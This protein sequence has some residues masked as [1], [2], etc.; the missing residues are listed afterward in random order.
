MC[1]SNP[2]GSSRSRCFSVLCLLLALAIWSQPALGQSSTPSSPDSESLW[3]ALLP[4]TQ[5][6]PAQYDNFMASLTTQIASLQDSNTQLTQTNSDLRDSN[7]QLIASNQSLTSKNELLTQS[8]KTSQ[9]QAAI[10]E[11]QSAQLQTDLQDSMLSTTRAQAD[12]KALERQTVWLKVY[13]VAL[14][15]VAGT[16][17]VYDYGRHMF[18]W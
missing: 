12:A 9:G 6:L 18:W 3:T 13:A 5:A 17:A 2:G 16:L 10:L 1:K 8:L 14:T 15:G 7:G 11:S 4:I